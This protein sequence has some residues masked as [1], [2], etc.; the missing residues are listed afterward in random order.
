[1]MVTAIFTTVNASYRLNLNESD[2]TPSALDHQ[3]Y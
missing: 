3:P 2:R 1:M